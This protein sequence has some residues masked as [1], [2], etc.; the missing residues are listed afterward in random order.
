MC[1]KAG[2]LDKE[3]MRLS[4]VSITTTGRSE[5]KESVLLLLL[6]AMKTREVIGL[7]TKSSA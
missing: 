4:W 2:V 5:S 1:I 3:E 6:V 7:G